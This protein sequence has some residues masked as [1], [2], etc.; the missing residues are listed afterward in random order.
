LYQGKTQQAKQELQLLKKQ[1]KEETFLAAIFG[2]KKSFK[3]L[4]KGL[5]SKE[6]WQF[7]RQSQIYCRGDKSK[8]GNL[9]TRLIPGNELI[10]K[11][12]GVDPSAMYL[13]VTIPVRN[14]RHGMHIYGKVHQQDLALED[15]KILGTNSYSIRLIRKKVLIPAGHA[16]Q[17]ADPATAGERIYAHISFL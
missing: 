1:R 11:V 5:L 15:W 6:D 3:Q 2:S 16:Q 7:L 14:Q 10:K 13:R 8:Q 4:Q 12:P 17:P 9:L